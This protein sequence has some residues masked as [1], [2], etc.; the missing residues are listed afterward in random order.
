MPSEL[1]KLTLIW[2]H[3]NIEVG[4]QTENSLFLIYSNQ[5]IPALKK[6]NLKKIKASSI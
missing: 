6:G 4:M 5:E 2:S 3:T 1:G